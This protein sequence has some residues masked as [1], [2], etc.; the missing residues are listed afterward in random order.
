MSPNAKSLEQCDPSPPKTALVDESG[1]R[2]VGDDGRDPI[3]GEQG[4]T[5]VYSYS[6]C[7]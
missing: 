3:V 4:Q 7:L 2:N 5:Q 1:A 6:D